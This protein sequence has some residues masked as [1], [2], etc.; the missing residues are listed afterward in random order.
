MTDLGKNFGER[1]LNTRKSKK[2]TREILAKEVNLSS[3]SIMLYEQGDRYPSLEIAKRIADALG[4]S[5]AYLVG[6]EGEIIEKARAQSG[7]KGVRDIRELLDEVTGLFSGGE[8]P[9]ED[10]DALM[11]AF[12]DAYFSAKEKNHRFTPKKYRKDVE[13]E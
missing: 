3:N 4:V 1:L 6:E 9:E 13:D 2:I 5:L 12:S 7:S 10:K 8:M 11:R